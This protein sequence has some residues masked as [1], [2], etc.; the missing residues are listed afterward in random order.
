MR[1]ALLSAVTFQLVALRMPTLHVLVQKRSQL[2]AALAEVQE[3]W[4]QSYWVPLQSIWWAS[5]KIL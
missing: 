4:F 1:A 5:T 3:R 2:L